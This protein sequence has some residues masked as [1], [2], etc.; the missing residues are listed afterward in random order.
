MTADK[1]WEAF[2]V[3]LGGIITGGIGVFTGWLIN[4]W[5]RDGDREAIKHAAFI[6]KVERRRVFLAF[7]AQLK[8]EAINTHPT[9]WGEFWNNKIPNLRHSAELILEDFRPQESRTAFEALIAAVCDLTENQI[10][11]WQNKEAIIE[12]FGKITLFVKNAPS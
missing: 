1:I 2:L 8:S 4:K 10:Y 9:H 5:Q 6:A 12:G 7:M 3:V 11:N